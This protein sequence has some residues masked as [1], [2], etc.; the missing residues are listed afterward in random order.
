M[1]LKTPLRT[2]EITPSLP[3]T[4]SLLG[5]QNEPLHSPMEL[6]TEPLGVVLSGRKMDRGGQHALPFTNAG[7]DTTDL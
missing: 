4:L 1:G 3:F 7:L 6:D 5:P 2:G